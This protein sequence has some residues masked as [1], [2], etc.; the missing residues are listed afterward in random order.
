MRSSQRRWVSAQLF[1]IT[2]FLIKSPW[3]LRL[4][5]VAD[6][7]PPIAYADHCLQ[8]T[9]TVTLQLSTFWLIVCSK[10]EASYC[11]QAHMIKTYILQL[12]VNFFIPLPSRAY[13][14]MRCQCLNFKPLMLFGMFLLKWCWIK[15]SYK[16]H[17]LVNLPSMLVKEIPKSRFPGVW[18]SLKRLKSMWVFPCVCDFFSI[19]CLCLRGCSQPTLLCTFM[20]YFWLRSYF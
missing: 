10:Y 14:R 1:T 17:Q 13:Y 3:K 7:L 4:Y 20:N 16:D 6:H 9:A 12:I 19:F 15:V 2:V 5:Q 18:R 11:L 8:I